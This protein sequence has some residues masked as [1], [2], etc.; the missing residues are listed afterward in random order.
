[1]Y[2][3]VVQQQQSETLISC[4]RLTHDFP[5]GCFSFDVLTHVISVRERVMYRRPLMLN[6]DKFYNIRTPQ[7]SVPG[8][9]TSDQVIWHL[10]M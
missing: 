2:V 8:E 3:I 6:H 7:G 5:F 10:D 4:G 1:M 9:T